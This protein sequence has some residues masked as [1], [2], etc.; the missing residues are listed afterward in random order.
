M[1]SPSRFE[2][3]SKLLKGNPTL[4]AEGSTRDSTSVKST[5]FKSTST[6]FRNLDKEL[7]GTADRLT[8]HLPPVW[9][10]IQ[11]DVDDNIITL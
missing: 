11:E 9:I 3:K 7:G 4:G 8:L 2:P 5:N 1:K 6:N 10:D